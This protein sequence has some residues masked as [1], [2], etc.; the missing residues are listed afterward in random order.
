MKIALTADPELP[1]PPPLY[2]GIER[3]VD[4]LAT[5]LVQRGHEVTLFAHRDSASAGR[6]A[7][8][9]AAGH[10]PK[11]ALMNTLAI[12]KTLLTQKF[13]L[14]HSFGRLAYLLPVLPSG[15]PKL[16]SYQREPTLSQVK[17]ALKLSAKGSLAFTGCSD[18]ITRKIS[19]FAKAATVYNGV[20][21]SRYDF[22]PSVG[23]DA[24]LM[25]LGRIEPV[26]GTHTAI[27]IALKTKKKLVIAG[28]IPGQ[29][30]AYFENEVQPFLN[31]Q[32]RYVGPVTDEQKNHWLGI[33]AALLMPIH[34]DEPFG[35][36]MI[37]AM[38]C[39]TPVL[40]FNRGAVPEVVLNQVTGF[41][42]DHVEELCEQVACIGGLDRQ[43]IRQHTEQR[44]GA[45]VIVEHYLSVYHQMLEL[46]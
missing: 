27:Q 25:F 14:V 26:K 36:V 29:H 9:P 13:D 20:D 17:R 12:N 35:I 19:P 28:N 11:D 24:P 3:M 8:Y 7:P 34:W 45:D 1:V 10:T 40:G 4:M 21:I 23:P 6:L 18:Y 16:M 43:T 44:F 41:Y 46:Q 15:L 38:A 22:N 37:E 42:S 39:G 30:Q 2:G 32:I 33:A 31:E 5:G